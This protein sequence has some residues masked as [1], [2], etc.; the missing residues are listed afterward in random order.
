MHAYGATRAGYQSV[1]CI[2]P[3]RLV[4]KAHLR[5]RPHMAEVNTIATSICGLNELGLLRRG[6][7][8]HVL[9]ILDPHFPEP[10][11]FASYEP[12]SR[13]T[14][15]FHDDI[16]AGTNIIL[17]QIAHME[18]ILGFGRSLVRDGGRRHILVHCHMGISRSTAAMAA[19]LAFVQS[20]Q[21]EET[22][23]ARL[24]TLRPDAWPNSLMVK[25]ADEVLGRRGRLT[26]ALRYLYA[27]QLVK[28]PEIAPALRKNGRGREVDMAEFPRPGSPLR[29]AR[30]RFQSKPHHR[31][32]L[33]E[34]A[35]WCE[36][37]H[38]QSTI[39]PALLPS[40]ARTYHC[41]KGGKLHRRTAA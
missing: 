26:R 1:R 17:P 8:T 39:M 3:V 24:L 2:F 23:F 37:R 35:A 14:L 5:V 30:R 40:I 28:R 34:I 6:G 32:G 16:D 10:D 33:A 41:F 20:D 4:Y 11:V 12:H 29:E 27:V 38:N 13:T 25:L 9:S 21:D 36:G 7:I 15:R 18:K 31:P 22:I 19:L